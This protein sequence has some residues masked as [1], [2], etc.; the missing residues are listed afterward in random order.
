[1]PYATMQPRD[2]VGEIAPRAL[3]ILG[4]ELD[5]VVPPA[6]ARTLFAAAKDPKQLWIV[7]GARHCDYDEVAPQEY[8]RR[9]REFFGAALLD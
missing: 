7:P 3:F 5:P 2:I 4:G 8:A 9:L 1:M 6:M